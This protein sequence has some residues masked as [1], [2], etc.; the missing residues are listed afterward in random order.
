VPILRYYSSIAQ[1]TT[2]AGS[3]SAGA[4][5]ITVAATTGFPASTPYTLAVDYGS[6]AEELV[7]VTAVAG[8]TLTVTRG[9]D[10]TSAQSHSLGAVVRHVASGRDFADYQTHQ[11]AASGVHGVTGAVVGTTDTQTLTNKTLTAPAITAATFTG[12]T[13]GTTVATAKVTGDANGRLTVGA[14]GT[15][16][17][18]SGTGA[19]DVT[20]YREQADVLTSNDVYRT[21][22]TNTTD[23]AYTARVT[24]DTNSRYIVRAD[25]QLAWGAGGGSAT[26]TNLYRS[27]VGALQTDNALTVTGRLTAQAGATIVGDASPSTGGVAI[28]AGPATIY[29]TE[30]HDASNTLVAA[31]SAAGVGNFADL[32]ITNP[33]TWASFPMASTT[34]RTSTGNATPSFGNAVLSYSYKIVAGVMNVAFSLTFGS[35]TNFGASPTTGD[36]WQFSLPGVYNVDPAWRGTQLTGGFG[37]GTST[38]AKTF[39][40][41]VKF[42]STG[43][44]FQFDIAGGFV[45]ATA[46]TNAGLMDSVSPFTWAS[47]NVI[48]FTAAFPVTPNP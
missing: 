34:W 3:V 37:R 35:T 40:F 32:Q 9:V 2:L 25:G 19:G 1:P 24:G 38:T 18:G 36:N 41:A 17:W 5:S 23:A 46:M 10:G 4:A 22:R 20:L 28:K 16:T 43:R 42:D 14:D 8:T 26:D 27:G 12:A 39:P 21:Y 11:A 31:V 15:L 45:D 47:G 30:F 13:A 44:Y 7:D 29:V 33:A 6:L 48:A